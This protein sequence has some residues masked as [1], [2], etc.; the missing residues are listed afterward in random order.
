MKIRTTRSV[1]TVHSSPWHSRFESRTTELLNR[2]CPVAGS[3]LHSTVCRDELDG[4][5]VNSGL[6]T[7]VVALSKSGKWA[8]PPCV[9]ASTSRSMYRYFAPT[10]RNARAGRSVHSG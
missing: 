7:G 5:G 9:C 1:A 2:Q 6:F 10:R 3:T 4:I 8:R